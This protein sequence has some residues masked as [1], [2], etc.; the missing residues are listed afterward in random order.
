MV[1]IDWRCTLDSTN[2]CIFMTIWGETA[3]GDR[4]QAIDDDLLI[5]RE[6][7]GSV[8]TVR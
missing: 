5:T 8:I 1:D 6:R 2:H 4:R 7:T 3:G